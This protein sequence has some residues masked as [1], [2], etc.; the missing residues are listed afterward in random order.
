MSLPG[1]RDLS[2]NNVK[3]GMNSMLVVGKSRED[4]RFPR[5]VCIFTASTP[6]NEFSSRESFLRLP[7]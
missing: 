1:E 7:K 5:N 2:T 6:L 3:D 4:D